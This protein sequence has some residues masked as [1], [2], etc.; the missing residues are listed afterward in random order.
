VRYFVTIGERELEV[1]I[2]GRRVTVD[3]REVAASLDRVPGSPVVRLTL[4]GR[5]HPLAVAGRD[6]EGW[7]I[8]DRGA[9]REVDAIDER[10]RHIRSLVS[11][12]GGG[13]GGGVVK[14]PM[15]GLVVQVLV[16]V[17]QAVTAGQGLVVLEAMK[18][19]NQ[20]KAPADGTV[21]AVTAVPGEPVEKGQVL[22]ELGP[23]S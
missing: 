15:P 9:V 13:A 8:V 18:M 19:E 1:I 20:L 16:E 17:G 7:Q 5:S 11:Q 23:E 4:D 2:D 12:T 6:P 3:G 22:V 10:T 14:A 21:I